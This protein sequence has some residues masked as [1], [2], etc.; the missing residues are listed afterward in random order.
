[1]KRGDRNRR[2]PRELGAPVAV[3]AADE[4]REAAAERVWTTPKLEELG[5][6]KDLVRGGGGK[7]SAQFDGDGRKPVGMG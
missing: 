1:M 7:L 3:R 5:R 2:S 6:V 4:G